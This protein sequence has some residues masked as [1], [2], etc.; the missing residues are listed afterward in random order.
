MIHLRVV[1]T[2]EQ[3]DG[4]RTGSCQTEADLTREFGM[5]ARHERSH[6]FVT[7][8]N[9]LKFIADSAEGTHDSIDAV[10]GVTIDPPKAPVDKPLK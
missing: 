7:N 9:K 5:G 3:M 4:A 6:L 10:A 1:K 2:V 8:L